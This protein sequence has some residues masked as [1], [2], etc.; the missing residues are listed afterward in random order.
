MVKSNKNICFVIFLCLYC[1]II[2]HLINSI[3]KL[4]EVMMKFSVGYRTQSNNELV[5]QIISY[6]K[7]I[8]EV[9]FSWGDTPSG[10]N[11]QTRSLGLTSWEAQ[12]KQI[13]DLTTLAKHGLKF[14]LLFNANCYG[15]HAQSKAFF[16]NVGQITDYVKN[17]FG[18]QSI[19]TTS[20]LIAKFI[21]QNFDGIDVRASVNMGVGEVLGMEY[22]KDFFDS[23]YVKREYNRDFAKLNELRTWCNNNGKEMYLLANSGCLNYCS[24]HT[25][26]DNLVAHEK[27]IAGM[28]NGYQFEG[29]CKKYLQNKANMG[30]LLDGTNFIRPEDVALYEG[31]VPA[32]KLATRVNSKPSRI[33]KAY[34]GGHY[35]GNTT[36][37]L[38]PNHSHAIYPYVLDNDKIK[39]KI[40]NQKLIYFD[41]ENAFVKLEDVYVNK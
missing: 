30:V 41:K 3:I 31:L 6:K 12:N 8:N 38:E 18:L 34:M 37:L 9:Y 35:S 22:I 29:V 19:T 17:N 25:F 27:Q 36:E 28:D 7:D 23:F 13:Q 39:S 5:E 4:S 1:D 10:R 26:H 2:K 15:E 20:P 16:D 14:N 33:F 21:K 40:E 11:D 24:A 32:M